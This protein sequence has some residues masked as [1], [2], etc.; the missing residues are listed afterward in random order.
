MT[1]RIEIPHIQQIVARQITLWHAEQR[2]RSQGSAQLAK[3]PGPYLTVSRQHGSGGAE[4]AHG[5]AQQ[6]RWE[7]YDRTLLEKMAERARVE[8]KALRR[9]EEGP[10]DALHEAIQLALDH[11]YPGHRQYL[12]NL[13]ATVSAAG[14]RGDV[15]LLGRGAHLILP[16]EFGLRVRVIA[17]L[18]QRIHHVARERG[19]DDRAAARWIEAADASQ[20]ALVRNILHRDLDDLGDYDLVI[21]TG[22]LPLPAAQVTVL[23]A[24]GAKLGL[25]ATV[26]RA[27]GAARA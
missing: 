8:P 1:I 23:A 5:L 22:A 25:A 6:L 24:L 3:Q 16:P 26:P 27:E 9:L 19:C 12:T 20:A 14:A 18:A 4:L 7:L 21:N 17:P 10:H 2:S 13:V 11:T 15:V